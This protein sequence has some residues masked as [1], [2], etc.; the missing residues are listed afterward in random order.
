MYLRKFGLSD[1]SCMVWPYSQVPNKRVYSFIPNERV[2]LLFWANFIGPN[3]RLGWKICYSSRVKKVWVY[4][5]LLIYEICSKQPPYSFIWPY[6]FI[7]HLRVKSLELWDHSFA[8]IFTTNTPS[9][10]LLRCCCI[11][12]PSHLDFRT[13]HHHCHIVLSPVKIWK[14]PVPL[15]CITVQ[16]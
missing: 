11:W 14:P 16:K 10:W 1:Q 5:G 3:K 6:L 2:V 8:Y 15:E 13:L 4:L 9:F 7:W 12:G